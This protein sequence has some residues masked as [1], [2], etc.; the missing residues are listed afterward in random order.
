[1]VESLS[2]KS[3]LVLFWPGGGILNPCLTILSLNHVLDNLHLVTSLGNV[4]ITIVMLLVINQ[5]QLVVDWH[6]MM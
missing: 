2:T 4:I 5:Y 3:K 6:L 1:M